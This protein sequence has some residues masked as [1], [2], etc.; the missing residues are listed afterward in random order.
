MDTG[1]IIVA[2]FILALFI[3]PAFL[4][5]RTGKKKGVKSNWYLKGLSA[6]YRIWIIADNRPTHCGVRY[7]CFSGRL[8]S[9]VFNNAEI[10][11][12]TTG[13]INFLR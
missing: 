11:I 13:I 12:F 3:T 6:L 10:H 5:N 9:I 8:K 2:I 7:L 4:F 1:T